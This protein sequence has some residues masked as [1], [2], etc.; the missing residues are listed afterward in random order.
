MQTLRIE[1]RQLI[2]IKAHI[3]GVANHSPVI[4][5]HPNQNHLIIR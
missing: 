2:H 5:G 1:A 3:D 4:T